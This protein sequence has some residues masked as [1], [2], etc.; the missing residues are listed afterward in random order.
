MTT[1]NAFA[2]KLVPAIVTGAPTEADDGV[3]LNDPARGVAVGV[4]VGGRGVGVAAGVSVC[5]IVAPRTLPPDVGSA[6]AAIRI[7]PT[8]APIMTRTSNL[9]LIVPPS[10]S[11]AVVHSSVPTLGALIFGVTLQNAGHLLS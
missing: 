5:R 10:N 8:N 6:S 7:A 4:G 11:P 3:T 9:I 2:E 1:M